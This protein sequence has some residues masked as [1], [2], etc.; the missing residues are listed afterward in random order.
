MKN[1]LKIFI[2]ILYTLIATNC[3]DKSSKYN[4]K[5]KYKKVIGEE[6]Q[7]GSQIWSTKN[8]NVSHYRNGDIIPQIINHNDWLNTTT[9]AWCWYNNDSTNGTIYG[10]LYNWYAVT[11]PRGLAPKGWHIPSKAEFD[12]LVFNVGL[13]E[14]GKIMDSCANYWI[15]TDSSFTNETGFSALPG[16]YKGLVMSGKISE[17]SSI[18]ELAA[19]WSSSI[20]EPYQK[21]AWLL[22]LHGSSKSYD[23]SYTIPSFMPNV[24]TKNEG[25]SV[26]CLKD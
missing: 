21:H 16:G 12:T 26:R 10:K 19:W 2:V 11:D 15:K 24:S 5:E 9:G 14:G 18:G 7:I 20:Y 17:F 6:T 25:Y 23:N 1:N 22:I 13:V 3:S 8:L 4:T